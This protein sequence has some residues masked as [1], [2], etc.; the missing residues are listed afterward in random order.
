[1]ER[2]NV[3]HHPDKERRSEGKENGGKEDEETIWNEGNE[4][5]RTF[6]PEYSSNSTISH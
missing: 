3:L 6:P 4:Q 2:N 5:N 1:M